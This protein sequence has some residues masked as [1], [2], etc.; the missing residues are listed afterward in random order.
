MF[1]LSS[2]FLVVF[3][4]SGVV[5][6]SVSGVFGPGCSG[7]PG[8]VSFHLLVYSDI[9]NSIFSLPTNSKG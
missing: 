6:G 8:L 2:S 3:H 4:W 9:Y 7:V 1:L 5:K